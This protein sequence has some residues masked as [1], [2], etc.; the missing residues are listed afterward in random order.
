MI[1][2]HVLI[3]MILHKGELETMFRFRRI[4]FEGGTCEVSIR[5]IFT[6]SLV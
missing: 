2:S 4:D 6:W 1:R 5:C 3:G